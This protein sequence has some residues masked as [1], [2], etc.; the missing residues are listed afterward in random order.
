MFT[1]LMIRPAQPMYCRCT[2]TVASPV[3]SCPNSSRRL[4]TDDHHGHLYRATVGELA[5]LEWTRTSLEDDPRIDIDPT[6]ARA[7]L[8]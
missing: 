2:P 8:A 1:P 3:F 6:H 5:G 4:Q 7:T